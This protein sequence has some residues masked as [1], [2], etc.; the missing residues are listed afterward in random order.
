MIQTY[1]GNG[2]GKTTAAVGAAVR[3]AG[4]GN[5][6][7]FVQFLKNNDSSE[8]KIL[9][10][11]SGIDISFSNEK[12]A[13][14]DNLNKE[15]TQALKKAYNELVFEDVKSKAASYKMIIFDEILDVIDF[16]YIIED[17]LLKLISKLNEHS[18]I[19][20]TGHMLTE[21]T[22]D[23]SDYISEVR[24]KKHPY[25]KGVFPRKGIEF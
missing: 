6:V 25:T 9:E 19:I 18:E 13:L 11:I 24:E 7:L 23:I 3:C 12:Y 8:F 5:K 15:R 21:K 2:K 4:C 22:A 14:Y 17:E 10:K 20:L 1:Y 16:G